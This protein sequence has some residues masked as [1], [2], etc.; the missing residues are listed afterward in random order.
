MSE[1][2]AARQLPS[3]LYFYERV[4]EY[5]SGSLDPNLDWPWGFWSTD[6]DDQCV[7]RDSSEAH[8]SQPSKHCIAFSGISQEDCEYTWVQLLGPWTFKIQVA[9]VSHPSTP[10]K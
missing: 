1:D 3:Q 5:A 8:L 7:M 9:Y 10:V 2:S 6:P 4:H